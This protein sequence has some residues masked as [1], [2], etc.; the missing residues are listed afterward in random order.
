MA[1]TTRLVQHEMWFNK[2]V[3]C[4]YPAA[5]IGLHNT[6]RALKAGRGLLL[7]IVLKGNKNSFT[8]IDGADGLVMAIR[9]AGHCGVEVR[10]KSMKNKRKNTQYQEGLFAFTPGQETIHHSRQ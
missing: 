10:S 4:F 7:L 8:A 2:R 9:C 3:I 1:F 5:G 6:G